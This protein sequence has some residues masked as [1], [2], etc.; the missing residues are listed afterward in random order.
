MCPVLYTYKIK[1]THTHTWILNWIDCRQLIP[2]RITQTLSAKKQL[3][4]KTLVLLNT[5]L[6]YAFYFVLY[7]KSQY[8]DFR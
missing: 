3:A 2:E 4:V 1:H 8:S 5:N 6:Y 7:L